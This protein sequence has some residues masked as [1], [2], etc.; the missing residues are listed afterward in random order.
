MHLNPQMRQIILHRP[1]IA[2]M[3]QSPMIP[4]GTCIA[5]RESNLYFFFSKLGLIFADPPSLLTIGAT[6]WRG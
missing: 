6:K 3:S 5:T 1:Q 4:T 2:I